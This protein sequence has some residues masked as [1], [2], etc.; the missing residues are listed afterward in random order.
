MIC[1]SGAQSY[2]ARSHIRGLD[3]DEV[4]SGPSMKAL[5]Y[6]LSPRPGVHAHVRA[7]E[8]RIRRQYWVLYHL[9]KAGFS[10]QELAKVYRTCLLPVADYC[11]V[12]YHAGL[13]NEQD[14]AVERLQAGMRCRM[15]G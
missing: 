7:L 8:K 2:E 12:V 6:H 4:R 10:D 15:R 1:I 11:Q 5:G 13:T 3:G 14:Q 9:R